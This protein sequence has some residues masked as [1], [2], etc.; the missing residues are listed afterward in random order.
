MRCWVPATRRFNM[1][2]TRGESK[3][4]CPYCGEGF[5]A[6]VDEEDTGAEYFE[7]CYVCCRPILFRCFVETDGSVTV[8]TS[9]DD[10]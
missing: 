5:T 8:Q 3:V 2:S 1:Q 10:E 9:R 7:D 4:Y 6:F